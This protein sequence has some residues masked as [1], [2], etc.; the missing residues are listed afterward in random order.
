M[1]TDPACPAELKEVIDYEAGVCLVA[2][3]Q[4]QR[5]LQKRNQS[6]KDAVE[7]LRKFVQQHPKHALVDA[8]RAQLGQVLVEQAKLLLQGIDA[9][10]A[11]EANRLRGE[12]R[13]LIEQ[14]K[15]DFDAYEK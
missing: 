11:E 9:K 6:L 14:A 1:A 13:K 15:Q 5:S 10:P 3:A 7:R 12:A 2:A 8:A 4:S